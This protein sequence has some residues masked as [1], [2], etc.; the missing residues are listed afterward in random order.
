MLPWIITWSARTSISTQTR[1]CKAVTIRDLHTPY[2]RS[3]LTC[4]ASICLSLWFHHFLLNR[5]PCWQMRPEMLSWA[6]CL[7]KGNVSYKQSLQPRCHCWCGDTAWASV[8]SSQ[9]LGTLATG[10]TSPTPFPRT[11]C[12]TPPNT[13]EKKK[14]E[15]KKKS[16]SV[17][18]KNRLSF[19][20]FLNT[21][22]TR[23]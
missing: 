19:C 1:S 12:V 9:A 17:H 10:P 11:D 8:P 23:N 4:T 16:L 13:A 5:Q 6:Q 7:L 18:R 3:L 15:T 14:Q 22:R 21:S 2:S 20:V